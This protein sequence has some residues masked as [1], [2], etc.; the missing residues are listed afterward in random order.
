M[1]FFEDFL[2]F[3][4]LCDRLEMLCAQGE[5]FSRL[6][7]S[8]TWEIKLNRLNYDFFALNVRSNSQSFVIFHVRLFNNWSFVLM[9]AMVMVFLWGR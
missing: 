7:E 3:L 4:E 5:F 8:L 6:M 1:M 2:I 9:V